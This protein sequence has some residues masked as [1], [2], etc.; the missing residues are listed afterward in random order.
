MDPKK[1]KTNLSQKV[2]SMRSRVCFFHGCL[3]RIIARFGVSTLTSRVISACPGRRALDRRRCRRHPT[4]AI[5]PRTSSRPPQLVAWYSRYYQ[6]RY[7]SPSFQHGTSFLGLL[8]GFCVLQSL[9]IATM[10]TPYAQMNSTPQHSSRVA[11]PLTFTS[12]LA[13]YLQIQ[14][15]QVLT[16]LCTFVRVGPGSLN[17]AYI[18]R[19]TS[20]CL[21]SILIIVVISKWDMGNTV[22]LSRAMSSTE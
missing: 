6:S 7:H 1:K 10:H 9:T 15:Q 14:V 13:W 8:L 17:C 22:V 11:L 5:A 19:D 21:R 20:S 2:D 3:L 12:L 16:W 18:H 4:T